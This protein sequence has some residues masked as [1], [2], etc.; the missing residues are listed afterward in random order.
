[1]ND[2][3]QQLKIKMILN[4]MLTTQMLIQRNKKL[5]IMLLAMLN[6]FYLRQTVIM[7]HKQKWQKQFK[8]LKELKTP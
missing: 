3:N 8:Q 4:L 2:L 5:I 7:R 6:T 1:M